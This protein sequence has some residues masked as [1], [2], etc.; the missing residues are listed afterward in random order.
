MEKE[1][2]YD[3]DEA[4]VDLEDQIINID[5][6]KKVNKFTE[7]EFYANL[8]DNFM[9]IKNLKLTREDKQK[10]RDA[11]RE[12]GLLKYSDW[13][14]MQPDKNEKI[15]WK[16]AVN[17]TSLDVPVNLF[18]KLLESDDDRNFDYIK[19]IITNEKKS[20]IG[21][22]WIEKN[23][24]MLDKMQYRRDERAD[25]IL[26]SGKEDL[27]SF[28]NDILK[29]QE[30]QN[31]YNAKKEEEKKRSRNLSNSKSENDKENVSF[32]TPKDAI[33]ALRSMERIEYK[34]GKEPDK[35]K[36]KKLYNQVM[37]NIMLCESLKF[38]D[39]E[40]YQYKR[41][42][43][44]IGFKQKTKLNKL[45]N[46]DEEIETPVNIINDILQS[47]KGDHYEKFKRVKSSLKYN[48][49]I[50]EWIS[51][52][53]REILI[54]EYE[55][56][57]EN[58]LDKKSNS[59]KEDRHP[60]PVN[61]NKPSLFKRIRTKVALGVAT[62]AAILGISTAAK[63]SGDEPKPEGNIS[64]SV[65]NN[66]IKD[67]VKPISKDAIKC[68]VDLPEFDDFTVE[69]KSNVKERY[70]NTSSN[71]I[72]SYNKSSYSLKSPDNNDVITS[73]GNDLAF[74]QNKENE[75][76]EEEVNKVKDN[77]Q[78]E[79]IKVDV[80]DTED[81]ILVKVDNEEDEKDRDTVDMGE[82]VF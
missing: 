43:E 32:K 50:K 39:N 67:S 53:D 7:R 22:V 6:S 64:K 41:A 4:I 72:S 33:D 14:K 24:A 21:K 34:K 47:T 20:S 31:K 26:E 62:T 77:I 70:R 46:I 8:L 75:I 61:K 40:V 38:S 78:N 55:N 49:D 65:A 5:Y 42:L 51:K 81:K 52:T 73:A 25:E 1:D 12:K 16:E 82:I 76:Y 74:N 69:L 3:I 63:A 29:E 66:L 30:S 19:D 28:V 60:V 13:K 59:R 18:S 57:L 15:T 9:R 35:L 37:K 36:E 45:R 11:L 17:S 48:K 56:S 54:S 23:R 10:Y 79:D 2:F 71:S 68:T 44:A 58:E 80:E 27:S